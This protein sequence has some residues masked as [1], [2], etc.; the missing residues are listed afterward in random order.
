VDEE[1]GQHIED[2]VLGVNDL[3]ED[4]ESRFTVLPASFTVARLNDGRLEN[5]LHLGKTLLE[6]GH[7]ALDQNLTGLEGDLG[8][9][10][11]L[12]LSQLLKDG[13]K[14]LAN[15]LHIG[16][17]GAVHV[18][19]SQDQVVLGT[20]TAV[21]EDSVD[22]TG[23]ILLVLLTKLQDDILITEVVGREQF[24][25]LVVLLKQTNEDIVLVRLEAIEVLVDDLDQGRESSL[26]DLSIGRVDVL[27]NEAN[28]GLL[29][30]LSRELSLASLGLVN[31]GLERSVELLGHTRVQ[32][33]RLGIPL[34]IRQVRVAQNLNQLLQGGTHDDLVVETAENILQNAVQ[35][36]ELLRGLGTDNNGR[37]KFGQL[38]SEGLSMLD[39]GG[40]I[41]GEDSKNIT[42]LE[43]GSGLLDELHN[44]IL[45]GNEGHVH[46]HDLNLGVSLA[47]ANVLAVLN[48]ELDKLTGGGSTELSRVILLL[49]ET[50]LA[51]NTQA[52]G[53]GF[54]LPV[55]IV[56]AS[57]EEN[58][59]T[60]VS[61]GTDTDG[62]LGAVDEEVVAVQAGASSSELIALALVYEVDGE[63]S[64]ENILG[65]DLALAKTVAV[66]FNSSLASEVGLGDST[67]NDSN[68]LVGTLSSQLV[69]DKLIQPSGGNGVVL[70]SGS[71]EKLNEVLDGGTEITTNTQFLEGDNHVLPRGRTVLTVGENVTELA[72]GETVNT[73]GST[74][75]EVTPDVGG[76]TEVQLVH[77]TA[78]RLEALTRVLG[79]DTTGSGVA[80]GLRTALGLVALL[81]GE[82]EINLGR[83][84]RIH[85]VEQTNVTDAVQGDTHGNLELSSGEVDSGN[86]LSGGMLDLKT[87]VQFEEVELVIGVRVQV[88]DGT[89]RDVS[90]QATKADSS[91]LHSL[92]GRLLGDS[93]RSL[94]NNLL[95][96]TLNGTITTEQG[97]VVTVLIS[98]QLNLQMAGVSSQLHDEDGRTRNLVG[99]GIVES[100]KFLLVLDLSDTLT[101]TTFGSLDHNREA[102]L[103]GLLQTFLRGESTSL[104]IDIVLDCHDA[105]FIELDS[106]DTG[107]RP[108]DT[109]HTSV[110]CNN[111]GR[112]LVTQGAH[113]RRGGSNENDLL[114]RSGQRFG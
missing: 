40:V 92:E 20:D 76:R 26:E 108:G 5:V 62:A 59:E 41:E 87:G 77:G 97:D 16:L 83:G 3:L 73:T 71:L 79:G 6:R 54:L 44:T 82:V 98:Q 109:W 8:G 91:A 68:N 46:L 21:G 95:M 36:E 99:G 10:A 80:L 12:E 48:G 65:G 52:S 14:V 107:S 34:S 24:L 4:L 58:Q 113:G 57:A 11:R 90:D 81:G 102:N 53:S 18:E 42:S 51:V 72:V 38:T 96:T 86:H 2:G 32:G 111:G 35:Q 70:E 101:T 50:G 22:N 49:E 45:L 56:T 33:R 112:N 84:V 94:L 37:A 61:K 74:D 66:L 89:S 85:T 13:L 93:D 19:N 23:D 25:N 106:V 67:T 110:L 15:I 55:D 43:G 103:L 9:G 75:R 63:D 29:E 88:L 27:L 100:D 30:L 104:A 105:V 17:V 47:G 1:T 64:L 114:R 28:N 39:A 31:H 60:A 7:G 78:G 69:G